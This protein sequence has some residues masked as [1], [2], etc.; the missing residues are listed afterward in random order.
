MKS[1]FW[2]KCVLL[3][4]ATY[5]PFF[6]AT[7][8]FNLLST[9]YPSIHNTMTSFSKNIIPRRIH[10]ERSQPANRV[11]KHGLLEKKKDYKQRAKYYNSRAARLKLLKEKASFRNPDEFYHAMSRMSTKDG[12]VTRVVD[13]SNAYAIPIANRTLDQR[14]LVETQDRK[15]VTH[16]LSTAHAKLGKLK[17]HLH[18]LD[19]VRAVPRKHVIFADDDE[20][21]D[22]LVEDIEN[23]RHSNATDGI[24]RRASLPKY[25]RNQQKRAYRELDGHV[26]RRLKLGTV[27][28]DMTVEKNLLSKGRRVMVRS[29]DKETGAP[30][31]F[32]WQQERSR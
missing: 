28:Q 26:D 11:A 32:R 12:V 16:K 29:P 20:D 6:T 18:F 7:H 31:V 4:P 14:L 25:L 21:A 9:H 27:F 22:K 1:S 2:F 30:A 8:S 5:F 23:E 10:R 19:A 13:Q 17:N 24:N 3:R 15:Y